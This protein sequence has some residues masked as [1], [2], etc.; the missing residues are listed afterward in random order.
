MSYT[1][2]THCTYQ[3]GYTPIILTLNIK[4]RFQQIVL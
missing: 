2:D 4:I 1:R 3:I